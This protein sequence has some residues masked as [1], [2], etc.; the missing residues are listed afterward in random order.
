M[1]D[2]MCC[3]DKEQSW[4]GEKTLFPRDKGLLPKRDISCCNYIPQNKKTKLEHGAINAGNIDFCTVPSW[5]IN[6]RC[7]YK[8]IP[9]QASL[10]YEANMRIL[11]CEIPSCNHL[12]LLHTRKNIHLHLLH[13]SPAIIT[14]VHLTV[15]LHLLRNMHSILTTTNQVKPHSPYP[16]SGRWHS[17]SYGFT[18][19]RQK[20]LVAEAL[21][22][23]LR[24]GCWVQLSPVG[25][26][27]TSH[28]LVSPCAVW[29]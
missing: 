25:D 18:N 28:A 9:A 1:I 23:N 14:P 17:H 6:S 26:V 19:P 29:D 10:Q 24:H 8:P 2:A 5:L 3:S 15:Y 27:A 11:N 20:G 4:C 21:D 16:G 13:F 12:L 7:S 22:Q